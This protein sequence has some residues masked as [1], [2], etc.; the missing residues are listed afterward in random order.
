MKNFNSPTLTPNRALIARFVQLTAV[1]ICAF[2]LGRPTSAQ[3][4]TNTSEAAA[5]QI[6]TTLP[7]SQT[8]SHSLVPNGFFQQLW[9]KITPSTEGWYEFSIQV[10]SPTTKGDY[11]ISVSGTDG[12]SRD[13]SLRAL[14]GE[15]VRVR[16]FIRA[17]ELAY[18][19]VTPDEPWSYTGSVSYTIEARK[20][21]VSTEANPKLLSALAPFTITGSTDPNGIRSFR[22]TAPVTGIY[23]FRMTTDTLSSH[24]GWCYET[25]MLYDCYG[26]GYNRLPQ[27]ETI[28]LTAGQVYDFGIYQYDSDFNLDGIPL[29]YELQVT[30]TSITPPANDHVA[31]AASI[32]TGQ[33]ASGTNVLATLET[34]EPFPS[35]F[36]SA[37]YTKSV[38]W[39]WTPSESRRYSISTEGSVFDTILSVWTG[40][41]PFVP[42]AANDDLDGAHTTS[43]VSFFATAGVS[44]QI[45]VAGKSAAEGSIVMA[46]RTDGPAPP[47]NDN[48]ASAITLTTGNWSTSPNSAATLEATE[49]FPPGFNAGNYTGSVWWKWTP[50]TTRRYVVQTSLSNFDTVLSL[51]TGSGP[52]SLVAYDND[53]GGF[54]TSSISF[55]ATAGTV[56]FIAVAGKAGASGSVWLNVDNDDTP[57]PSNDNL[58]NA[59]TISTDEDVEGTN[60]LASLETAE[61][62]PPDLLDQWT[63]SVWYRWTAPSTGGPFFVN[64]FSSNIDTGHRFG[65]FRSGLHPLT[66]VR[67]GQSGNIRYFDAGPN[68]VLFIA[69]ASPS[70]SAGNFSFRIRSRALNT[71]QPVTKR[72]SVRIVQTQSAGGDLATV[73]G[74]SAERA[75]VEARIDE[76]LNQAGID[77]QFEPEIKVWQNQFAYIGNGPQTDVRSWEDAEQIADSIPPAFISPDGITA[78]F[79]KRAPDQQVASGSSAGFWALG[80][81][82]DDPVLIFASGETASTPPYGQEIVGNVFASAICLNLGLWQVFPAVD[83][84]L[85][86]PQIAVGYLTDQQI[87][88][89]KGTSGNHFPSVRL[90]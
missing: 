53:S 49:P 82:N 9:W 18:V 47:I 48:I 24:F 29:N 40:A 31:S 36:D 89:L 81:A 35:G 76:V 38:W 30:R 45:A 14:P 57:V 84:N 51:W 43:R 13:S 8:G 39:K 55:V 10:T 37:S 87:L 33:T 25:S 69:V 19:I 73:F 61:G 72:V 44:Y 41:G 79:V 11:V 22:Y 2:Q 77:V 12:L 42:I 68:E 21:V 80:N 46:I 26:A 64:F 71:L 88:D 67:T 23:T 16:T 5:I 59:Q 54:S 62:I 83:T 70:G 66:V 65:I 7:W 86:S 34:G 17:A 58:A 32:S 3:A 60:A 74:T 27:G 85:M 75:A 50:A 56:Y 78:C 28:S 20:L 63:Q 4:A 90:S 6:P 1:L 15:K 52:Y